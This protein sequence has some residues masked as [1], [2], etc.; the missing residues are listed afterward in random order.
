MTQS[1]VITVNTKLSKG[2]KRIFAAPRP[3]SSSG[4]GGDCDPIQTA[5]CFYPLSCCLLLTFGGSMSSVPPITLNY[6]PQAGVWGFGGGVGSPIVTPCGTFTIMSF[7][8][9]STDGYRLTISGHEFDSI[10]SGVWRPVSCVSAGSPDIFLWESPDLT[11]DGGPCAGTFTVTVTETSCGGSGSGP[12]DY[13]IGVGTLLTKEGT[14]IF[15]VVNCAG[16]GPAMYRIGRDTGQTKNGKRIFA[17]EFD[18]CC[19]GGPPGIGPVP[20]PP[21]TPGDQEDIPVADGDCLFGICDTIPKY[22]KIL[23]SQNADPTYSGPG[24]D[25]SPFWLLGV[26]RPLSNSYE[27]PASGPTTGPDGVPEIIAGQVVY[28][29]C[30]H[31]GTADDWSW[32]FGGAQFRDSGGHIVIIGGECLRPDIDTSVWRCDPL[33]IIVT[34]HV[35]AP[36]LRITKA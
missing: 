2:G 5:F 12:G 20:P 26:W 14:R 31:S 24:F 25:F 3:C 13:R 18:P 36:T 15:G 27:F 19:D 9:E 29:S 32:D 34:N 33:S 11:V 35:G 22:V 23:V 4:G 21:A 1:R 10:D 16:S 8:G 30:G 6:N 28:C 17:A 7:S